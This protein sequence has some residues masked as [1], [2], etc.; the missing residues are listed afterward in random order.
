MYQKTP[1]MV[2]LQFC[3]GVVECSHDVISQARTIANMFED[4]NIDHETQ[5]TIPIP[6][7]TA[8]AFKNLC[9]K[10]KVRVNDATLFDMLH[11]S[12]LLE[13]DS[14]PVLRKIAAR[15]NMATIE[16]LGILF[17]VEIDFEANAHLIENARMFQYG[18]QVDIDFGE[19]VFARM[20]SDML[21]L[22]IPFLTLSTVFRMLCVI[23]D[24]LQALLPSTQF[25]KD[26]V[27]IKPLDPSCRY[28]FHSE[29]NRLGINTQGPTQG[30]K[31][32]C[33]LMHPTSGDFTW[34][35]AEGHFAVA[36]WMV[37]QFHLTMEHA[38][39][40]A[41]N[42]ACR[43]GHLDVAKWL[44]DYFKITTEDVR[45]HENYTLRVS[46][47]CGQL[48]VAQWLVERFQ[49]TTGDIKDHDNDALKWACAN[50]YVS[51]VQWLI[52]QC[53]L[54]VEDVRENNHYVLQCVVANGRLKVLQ[55]LFEHF[56]LTIQ[57][58]EACKKLA[59]QR[60]IETR[61][62]INWLKKRI[63]EVAITT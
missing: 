61:E 46:C 2:K 30:P 16:Q 55:W 20:T 12:I 21:S 24:R 3:D 8:S 57:D 13:M 19:G 50:G 18:F 35:C 48:S 43:N 53:K 22:L 6:F 23:P 15:L 10:Y 5:D 59:L 4:L 33:F 26:A 17:G 28:M 29:Y 42:S 11:T 47:M 44:A 9:S 49:L 31:T 62:M 40:D 25:C 60:K 34:A 36:K 7:G 39:Q 56:K 37:N 1:I 63:S 58:A 27:F 38:T 54:T 52:E 41:F 32:R 14:F 45:K 51:V